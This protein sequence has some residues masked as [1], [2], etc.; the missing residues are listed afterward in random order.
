MSGIEIQQPQTARTPRATQKDQM[1]AP[2]SLLDQ[3]SHPPFMDIAVKIIS[4][5]EL[6][7]EAF[8]KI[9]IPANVDIIEAMKALNVYF[10][11]DFPRQELE[12]IR[13]NDFI[14][15]SENAGLSGRDLSKEL[16]IE[17]NVLVKGTLGQSESEAIK[18]LESQGL[19]LASPA[20]LALVV[21]T[22]NCK[23]LG[24]GKPHD[25]YLLLDNF[26]RVSVP[27]VLMKSDEFGAVY[28]INCL[29]EENSSPIT[30]SS[31]AKTNQYG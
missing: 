21:A 11:K 4:S 25:N 22:Y 2:V 18:V 20:A 16:I 9:A 1:Y 23:N 30:G 19:A 10:R 6:R 13:Q 5:C 24:T 27:G 8:V 7:D 17:I 12:A 14:F 29:D 3:L 15:Y 26:T 28:I 31:G